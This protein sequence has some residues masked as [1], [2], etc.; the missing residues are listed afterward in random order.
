MKKSGDEMA[1]K[2]KV[3]EASGECDTQIVLGGQD[4]NQDRHVIFSEFKN[5]VFKIK[6]CSSQYSIDNAFVMCSH[7]L[8]FNFENKFLFKTLAPGQTQEIPISMKVSL[9]GN[10]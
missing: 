7:P 9:I 1:L 3:I 4:I 8:L 2:F 10:I 6:N 5:G